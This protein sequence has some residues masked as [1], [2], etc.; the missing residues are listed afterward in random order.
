MRQHG[1][2]SPRDYAH[3]S[4]AGVLEGSRNSPGS[5]VGML[6]QQHDC[7]GGAEPRHGTGGNRA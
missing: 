2:A 4:E 3:C 7:G 1:A 6:E 5:A